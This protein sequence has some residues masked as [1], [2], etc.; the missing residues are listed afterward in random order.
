MRR[1]VGGGDLWVT[2]YTIAYD[3]KPVHVVSIMEFEGDLVER[4]TH[5]FADPFDPPEWRA[6]WVEAID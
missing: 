2:E 3:E 6:Q 4:E 1:I 5:Y